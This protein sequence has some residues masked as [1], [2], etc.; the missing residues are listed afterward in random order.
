MLKKFETK[1]YSIIIK[2]ITVSKYFN[3]SRFYTT[4]IRWR[5]NIAADC[6]DNVCKIRT[7]L[8]ISFMS[9]ADD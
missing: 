8:I 9:L 6:T 7:I 2:T 3:E 5:W 4:I 1:N